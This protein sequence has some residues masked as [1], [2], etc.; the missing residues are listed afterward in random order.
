MIAPLVLT[1]LSAAPSPAADGVLEGSVTNVYAYKNGVS[2]VTIHLS[3][4][5]DAQGELHYELPDARLVLGGVWL[6]GDAAPTAVR[7][8][9]D[10]R[11]RTRPC[12]GTAEVLLANVGR[13]VTLLWCPP[14]GNVGGANPFGSPL[15]S[16]NVAGTVVAVLGGGTDAVPV[17]DATRSW[18]PTAERLV[19]LRTRSGALQVLP[20]A[21]IHSVAGA[22]LA[23]ELTEEVP[24]AWSLEFELDEPGTAFECDLCFLARGIAWRAV[25]RLDGDLA[26]DDELTVAAEL[27]NDLVDLD[28]ADVSLVAGVPNF[29]YE[30]LASFLSGGRDTDAQPVDSGRWQQQLSMQNFASNSIRT[31]GGAPAPSREESA[32]DGDLTPLPIGAVTLAKGGRALV[33]MRREA[34]PVEHVHTLDLAVRRGS[35]AGVEIA[36]RHGAPNEWEAAYRGAY[37]SSRRSKAWHRIRLTNRGASP[38]TAGAL[39]VVRRGEGPAFPLAQEDLRYTSPGSTTNVPLNL[40]LGLETEFY[41]ESVP[42]TGVPTGTSVVQGHLAITNRTGG[43]VK[44]VGRIGVGGRVVVKTGDARVSHSPGRD[45][46]WTGDE[47]NWWRY[48][49]ERNPHAEIE[50]EVELAAGATSELVY[51]AEYDTRRH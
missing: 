40:A 15:E 35:L 49:R 10:T 37:A 34:V 14:A 13:D 27:S 50:W 47:R 28:G 21:Q 12:E 31:A 38:W 18:L 2:L 43:A 32:P 7:A 1:V 48:E 16:G 42:A 41:E 23:T 19:V 4:A 8:R 25:Y 9:A 26:A 46:D 39:L 36:D 3:G 45:D 44:L 20:V 6:E 5:S 24:G 22:D 33:T 30:D 11:T 51:E 29:R 17:Q